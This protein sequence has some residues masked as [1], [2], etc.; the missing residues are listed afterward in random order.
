[1]VEV[2]QPYP[3]DV[4]LT[5]TDVG[6]DT[7][8]NPELN[9]TDLFDRR[10]VAAD[11][12][13]NTRLHVQ[14]AHGLEE[15]TW[16]PP[17]PNKYPDWFKWDE[18]F[19]DQMFFESAEYCWERA[20]V[21]EENLDR[22]PPHEQELMQWLIEEF[23]RRAELYFAS[24]IEGL[25]TSFDGMD[26]ETGN[27]PNFRVLTKSGAR[28]RGRESNVT[29]KKGEKVS[30]YTQPVLEPMAVLAGLRAAKAVDPESPRIKELLDRFYEP[31][32][33]HMQWYIDNL[34]DGDGSLLMGI[35]H[36]HVSGRDSDW[37]FN[38]AK[39]F[40]EGADQPTGLISR[41]TYS[42]KDY[43]WALDR[44]KEIIEAD[45]DMEKVREG[46]WDKDVMFNAIYLR[47]LYEMAKL[48][49]SAA[50]LANN[51][52]NKKSY[53]KDE[54]HYLELAGRLEEEI[55]TLWE[56]HAW[57]G[58][59]AFV[60][61]DRN[62]NRI[63]EVSISSLFGFSLRTLTDEQISSMMD[64][65][66]TSFNTPYGVP[67]NPTDS[68]RFAPGKI[69]I[70]RIWDD[71]SSWD[72]VNKLLDDDFC[73]LAERED[74]PL[75][76]R[77]RIA[78]YAIKVDVSSNRALDTYWPPSEYRNP[79]TGEPLRAWWARQFTWA[80]EPRFMHAREKLRGLLTEQETQEILSQYEP[81]ALAA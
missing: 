7:I 28:Q 17:S 26:E 18:A 48:A 73:R 8:D 49:S 50:E 11:T 16:T 20:D 15:I 33:L 2:V 53:E 54:Q 75:E 55:Q 37:I 61:L 21:Y 13:L 25:Q 43:D 4:E 42:K 47:S 80:L 3:G 29:N 52:D 30:A 79:L 19:A 72:N 76:L 5:E 1:M 31:L 40:L 41:A 14:R 23:R 44:T 77:K 34:S 70:Q 27:M 51:A 12:M 68:P 32:K 56:P 22:W 78:K 67:C 71:G 81:V 58:N 64:L 46:F 57:M 45:G 74:L 39:E 62:G 65:V 9:R 24:A 6:I 36:P 35:P 10:I 60:N 59:G 63:P 69:G 66:E 38:H